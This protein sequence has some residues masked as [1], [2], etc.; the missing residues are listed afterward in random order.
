MDFFS[1]ALFLSLSKINLK[2][3]KTF[4]NCKIVHIHCGKFLITKIYKEQNK[5][6]ALICYLEITS[7]IFLNK[8]FIHLLYPAFRSLQPVVSH[9]PEY[10]SSRT[11]L[12]AGKHDPDASLLLFRPQSP[13]WERPVRRY[14]G[15]GK[16]LF[17]GQVLGQC[18]PSGPELT[19]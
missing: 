12:S 11:P 9:N 4:E 16:K 14:S 18:D 13:H 8:K 19:L 5:S 1:L 6:N 2:K 3:L 17:S 10:L 15:D 7:N